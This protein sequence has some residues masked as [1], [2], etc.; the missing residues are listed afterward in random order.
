[1]REKLEKEE[2]RCSR[3]SSRQTATPRNPHSSISFHESQ[4]WVLTARSLP[5]QA[6][7]Q[8]EHQKLNHELYT[9][10]DQTEISKSPTVAEAM[11]ELAFNLPTVANTASL[12]RI[13]SRCW[14]DLGFQSI[15]NPRAV[16]VKFG[17]PLDENKP[18]NR[19]E[20]W[21]P[22]NGSRHVAIP[23]CCCGAR[24]VPRRPTECGCHPH[25]IWGMCSH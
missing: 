18:V 17:L 19:A 11:S 4:G 20:G 8:N 1:M 16:S 10:A 9:A 21:F 6:F 25:G 13:S 22:V 23:S 5:S 14:A 3:V 24:R 7:A 12:L 15:M 2:V